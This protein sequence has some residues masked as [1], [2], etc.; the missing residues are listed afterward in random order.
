VR[1]EIHGRTQVQ[2]EPRRDF[3]IFIVHPDVGRH[4]T[5]GDVPIDVTDIVVILILAQIGQIEA[6]AAKQ[7]LVIAMK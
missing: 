7:G 3:S 6:E 4:E 2:Q 1:A 5:R